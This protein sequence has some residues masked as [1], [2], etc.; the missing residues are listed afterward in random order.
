MVFLMKYSMILCFI[1]V[2]DYSQSY[3]YIGR[4][5][6]VVK[7]VEGLGQVGLD[8][9]VIGAQNAGTW[10]TVADP[11]LLEESAVGASKRR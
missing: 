10:R 1:Y 9:G 4:V 6:L 2:R 3:L 5:E 7:C 8:L 11:L